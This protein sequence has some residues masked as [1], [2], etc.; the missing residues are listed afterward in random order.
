ME[1]RNLR[2]GFLV[3]IFD[4]KLKRLYAT[5]KT[6][7]ILYNFAGHHLRFANGGHDL[8]SDQ[9][10][11]SHHAVFHVCVAV[12]DCDKHWCGILCHIYFSV[13]CVLYNTY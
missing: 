2:A 1:P 3:T 11:I 6:V 4:L 8:A 5:F 13:I 9:L 12:V 7:A 10:A